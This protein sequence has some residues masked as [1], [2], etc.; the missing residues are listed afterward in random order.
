MSYRSIHN[1]DIDA[2]KA[3]SLKSDLIRDPKGH[4]SDLCKQY[5][6]VLKALL[7]RHAPITTNFK[8]VSHV[9][10]APL[11]I[12]QFKRRRRYFERVRRKSRSHL[13]G[14]VVQNRSTNATHKW[15]RSNRIIIQ[16]WSQITLKIHVSYGIA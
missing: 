9:P 7:N 12:L 13:G 5:Y 1:I 2:F 15:L 3:D 6:Y 10:P 16:I 14:H 11:M 8:S 4:L